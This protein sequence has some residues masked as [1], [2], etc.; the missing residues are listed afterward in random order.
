MSGPVVVFSGGGTGGH[1]VPGL[2]VAG[3]LL[4][5]YPDAHIRFL[6]L[7][8]EVER[9]FL[10][11]TPY[12]TRRIISARAPRGKVEL[13]GTVI[14]LA[15]G[16][17]QCAAGYLRPRPDVVVG[18]G[19]YGSIPGLLAAWLLRVPMTQIEVNRSPGL[20]V[21]KLAPRCRMTWTVF[22]EAARRL[23]GPTRTVGFPLPEGYGEIDRGEARGRFGLDPSRP[24]VV[25]VGGSQ[26]ASVLNRLMTEMAPALAGR[27][28]QVLHQA[29]P[30]E[31]DAVAR[32]FDEAGLASTVLPFVDDMQAAWSAA[33]VVVCRA[34]AATVAELSAVGRATVFVPFAGAAEAH[35]SKNVEA[36]A[37]DDRAEVVPEKDAD[38]LLPIKIMD[39]LDDATRRDR[40]A[41]RM[42]Q[43]GRH[44]ATARI[45]DD[46]AALI[47]TRDVRG[48][49]RP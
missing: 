31:A 15:A 5:R 12:H 10:D 17:V 42:K 20:A 26:G 40:L 1:L 14:R 30:A 13:P 44:D 35:Q 16:T 36:L 47:E 27:D 33:D 19:G 39:L 9:R 38:H 45:A 22:D 41:R 11:N 24:T 8:R 48:V 7:G 23:A 37:E 28:V 3:A 2:N 43:D 49:T 46:L 25:V 4:G 21:R 29:G 6:I 18:L 32:A 34:G